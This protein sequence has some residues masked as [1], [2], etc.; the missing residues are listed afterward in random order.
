MKIRLIS[1]TSVQSRTEREK[2]EYITD[3]W[4]KIQSGNIHVDRYQAKTDI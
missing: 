3:L 4:T 1:E 2:I